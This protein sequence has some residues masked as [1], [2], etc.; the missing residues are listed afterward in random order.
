M[1]TNNSVINLLVSWLSNFLNIILQFA[2][3]SIF[4]HTLSAEYL[5]LNGLFSNILS[6][7]SFAELGF[8]TAITFSLYKPLAEND[9]KK[10]AGIM[11]FFK[12]VY[13]IVGVIVLTVGA[14]LTP[15]LPYL[16]NEMPDIPHLYIIYLLWVFNSGVSYF[17]VYKSTLIIADQ[18]KDIVEKNNI[19]FKVLQLGLQAIVLLLTHNYLMYLLIQIIMTIATNFSISTIS[20]KRYKYLKTYKDEKIEEETLNEIKKNVG[21]TIL[22]KIGSVV[23]FG[24]DN[25][26]LSKFF[27]LIVVGLY[28]NYYLIINT[29]ANLVGQIQSSIMASVGN[30][31]A[32]ASNEKKLQ[33]FEQYCFINFWIYCFT[34]ACLVSLLDPFIRFWIGSEYTISFTAVLVLVFNY[35]LSG[36]RSAA[37][38]FNNAFGLF[39]NT[40]KLPIADS[41]LNIV[42]SI[43]LAK[44]IGYIGVF[45]GT[46]FSSLLAGAWY[47]PYILYKEG[48]NSTVKDY[49]RKMVEY[50]AV[51]FVIATICIL[52]VKAISFS[53]MLGLVIKFIFAGTLSNLLLLLIYHKS[54][55]F[56]YITEL[57]GKIMGIIKARKI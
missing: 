19:V 51:A 6:F 55:R 42:I 45:L 41:I 36:F 26:L 5:G 48:F 20:D 29:L 11:Q 12:H 14:M 50:F 28:S 38:T 4:I 30:L 34:S 44:K 15:F 24:T 25:I 39:W 49:F 35:F 54:R 1:R 8:G 46:T 23:V 21:A 53:G 47:E 40:R 57:F 27:G 18:R 56:I 31:G 43:V 32:I 9:E 3:R 37:A 22:H 16:I 52:A 2:L 7:L 10:V 13:F 17:W 33:I